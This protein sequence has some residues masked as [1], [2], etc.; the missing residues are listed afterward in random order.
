VS[1]SP[2]GVP[3]LVVRCNARGADPDILSSFL[4]GIVGAAIKAV[5]VGFSRSP[6]QGSY[7]G[8]YAALSDEVIEKNYNGYYLIDPAKEGKESKQGS[9]KWLIAAL[10][11]LSHRLLKEKVGDDALVAWN[12]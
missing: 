1:F 12:A 9:D 3:R 10:W 2:K 8:L 4:L 7:S 5:S 6:E 11:D